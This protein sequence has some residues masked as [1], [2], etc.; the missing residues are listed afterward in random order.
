M[1]PEEQFTRIERNLAD[2]GEILRR[3]VIVTERNEERAAQ[4]METFNS[5]G[6]ILEKYE[7]RLANREGT[8]QT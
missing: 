4:M 1:T 6:R 7:Q 8:S 5:M 3:I 2:T